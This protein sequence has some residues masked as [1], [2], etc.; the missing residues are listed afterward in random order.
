MGDSLV[1]GVEL[2]SEK[3]NTL[4][5]GSSCETGEV[6]GQS[7]FHGRHHSRNHAYLV[8]FFASFCALNRSCR[9]G[10]NTFI[11]SEDSQTGVDSPNLLW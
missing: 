5:I 11:A 4:F 10:I 9:K 8:F 3:L 6:Q 7:F 1:S 2:C